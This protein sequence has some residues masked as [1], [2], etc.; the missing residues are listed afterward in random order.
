MK[1]FNAVCDYW[2]VFKVREADCVS[3]DTLYILQNVNL[4]DYPT[5]YDF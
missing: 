2:W 1:S 5:V 3:N 4:I